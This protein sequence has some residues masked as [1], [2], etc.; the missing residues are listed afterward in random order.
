MDNDFWDDDYYLKNN[1]S[2]NGN[3]STKKTKGTK[4]V[5]VPS[6]VS[7]AASHPFQGDGVSPR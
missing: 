2:N 7:W 3:A 1:D 5:K 4:P 6:S